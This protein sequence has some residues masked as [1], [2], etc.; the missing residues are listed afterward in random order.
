MNETPI[1]DAAHDAA[2]ENGDTCDPI[3][4]MTELCRRFERALIVIRRGDYDNAHDCKAAS[5]VAEEVL[6]NK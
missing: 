6:A 1:T 2:I 4:E 5:R 3:E